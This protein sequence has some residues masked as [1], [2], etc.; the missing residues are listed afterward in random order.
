MKARLLVL[1]CALLSW[2]GPALAQMETVI[3]PGGEYLRPYKRPWL[4]P[5][6][7]EFQAGAAYYSG[8]LTGTLSIGAQNY[9]LNP[10]LSLGLSYRLT[11]YISLR[12]QAS[13]FRLRITANQPGWGDTA[14]KSN[15]FAGTFS[16]VHDFFS[17]RTT[18][19]FEA[20]VNPYLGIGVGLIHFEPRN[21]E[22]GQRYRALRDSAGL[23]S[24]S[25]KALVIPIT[26]GVTYTLFE[27]TWIGLEATY[28]FARTDFLDNASPPSGSN[29]DGFYVFGV[30]AGM[31]LYGFFKYGNYLKYK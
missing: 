17:K 30:R 4:T 23:K 18:E 19:A 22:N 27:D 20:R 24:Y 26:F 28:H 2:A 3:R 25:N 16:V 10:S 9:L 1:F 29:N 13:Y 14:V 5:F 8:D 7:V 21:P 15:N 6:T 11:D 12:A 31:Q